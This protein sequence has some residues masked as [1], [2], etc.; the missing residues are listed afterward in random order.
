LAPDEA[1]THMIRFA[2]STV[3]L[4]LLGS[5]ASEIACVYVNTIAGDQ[6]MANGDAPVA[7]ATGTLDH[8]WVGVRMLS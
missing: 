3:M 5:F 6:L 4:L 2:K 8:G 7:T 1:D